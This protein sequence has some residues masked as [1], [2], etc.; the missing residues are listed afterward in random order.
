M[1][2]G[3]RRQVFYPEEICRNHRQTHNRS[4]AE[5]RWCQRSPPDGWRR[6]DMEYKGYHRAV[7][8]SAMRAG[9][10]R[11][12][13]DSRNTRHTA[14]IHDYPRERRSVNWSIWRPSSRVVAVSDFGRRRSGDRPSLVGNY[15]PTF[16]P[17]A[18][19]LGAEKRRCRKVSRATRM[20]C[21]HVGVWSRDDRLVLGFKQRFREFRLP[22]DASQGSTPDRIVKRN[23]NG[24]CRFLQ[25][26]LH[27]PVAALLPGCGESVFV[28]ESDKFP[29]LKEPGVYPT[30]TST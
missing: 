8:R 10:E 26:L 3:E 14:W 11:P 9:P 17:G 13:I 27:D 19:S 28:R 18:K 12:D 16:R 29:S 25:A 1:H 24:Y 5:C 15:L 22:N 7:T 21:R 4:S 20:S 2:S 6:C 23:R 30:G